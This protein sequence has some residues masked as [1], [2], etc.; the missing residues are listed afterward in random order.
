MFIFFIKNFLSIVFQVY[1]PQIHNTCS[2]NFT[3][4]K[5]K[6]ANL[7]IETKHIYVT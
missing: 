3:K 7:Q 5:W 2:V 6:V 1:D 4:A